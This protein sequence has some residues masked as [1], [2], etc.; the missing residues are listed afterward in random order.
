MQHPSLAE[1][2]ILQCCHMNTQG[3]RVEDLDALRLHDYLLERKL[4]F[5]FVIFPRRLI[6]KL[7]I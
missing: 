6:E 2:K 3:K 5:L 7:R 1:V 4:V